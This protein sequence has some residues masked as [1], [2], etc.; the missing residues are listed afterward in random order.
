MTSV[1]DSLAAHVDV[2]DIAAPM[3]AG[4]DEDLVAALRA[5]DETA[6]ASLL[7]GHYDTMLR[8]ARL[9][10]ATR[11]AAE[12]VVQETFLGVIKGIDR[13]EARS[14]FRTWMFRILVNQAKTRG[15][16]ERRSQP[17]SSL[18]RELDANAPAVDPERFR[19]DGRWAG[20]GCTPPSTE[21]LPEPSVLA[22]EAGDRLRRGD[23]RPAPRPA[24]GH[25]PAGCGR[26]HL[27]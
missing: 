24:R 4:D 3:P 10:V 9:H 12:D 17:F 11:E 26:S 19:P 16:R 15:E 8:V 14:S 2:N 13:F 7:D 25:D 20:F 27:G 1:S 5:G 23:R 18:E 22:G 6:F 21:Q